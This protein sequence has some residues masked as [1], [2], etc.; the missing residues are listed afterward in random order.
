ME[1]SGS[2]SISGS[3]AEESHSPA[4]PQN[5]SAEVLATRRL[6]TAALAA[7]VVAGLVSWIAG[8]LAYGAFQPRLH[9]SVVFGMSSMQATVSSEN[10]AEYKNASLA[11]AILGGVTGLVMGIAGGI[12][13]RS[14]AR[15]VIVGLIFQVVGT[16]VGGLASLALLRL[17]Y[18][19][20]V[21]DPN[22][23]FTPLLVQ[24]GIWTAVGAVGGASF[25]IGCGL[26]RRLH[27]TIISASLGA[28]FATILFHVLGQSFYPDSNFSD[29][30][31]N[32]SALRLMARLLVTVLVAVG[33]AKEIQGA[34]RRPGSAPASH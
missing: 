32:L 3:K 12:A 25:A 9:R 20:Y 21:R 15:G 29:P 30:L 11:F 2:E 18:R 17:L 23:M 31:A 1:S 6:W 8:E 7:G 19:G 16:L 10:A 28:I 26:R 4:G 14:T 34:I 5:D 13:A 22:D 27:N 24:G 33:V